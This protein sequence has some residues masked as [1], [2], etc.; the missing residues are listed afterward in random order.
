M[1]VSEQLQE[2]ETFTLQFE[3]YLRQLQ[4]NQWM[5][6]PEKLQELATMR[7]LPLEEL[8]RAGIFYICN[9]AEML[10]P[11]YLD[12]V[13]SFGVI[14]P[15]NNAPIYNHRWVMPIRSWDGKIL[16]LVGYAPDKDERYIYGTAR[17]YRRTDTPYGLENLHLAYEM[18]YALYTEGITDALRLRSLGYRNSFGNCGTHSSKTVITMLN[19]CKHGVIVIPDRDAPGRKAESKWDFRNKITLQTFIKYKDIDEMCRENIN[20][21]EWVTG[22]INS[23][24]ELLIKDSESGVQDQARE[25]TMY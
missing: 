7:K 17:Y 6:H 10:I 16:N 3:E 5:N 24:I 11:D 23:A 18:G 4:E 15:T 22:Y 2:Y 12:Q 25:Y 21:L 1:G 9:Q 19:R 20:D 14:S 13:V 8:Q